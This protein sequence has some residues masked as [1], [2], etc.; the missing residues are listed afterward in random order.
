MSFS[1]KVIG[2]VSYNINCNFTNY[3]SALQ[4]WALCRE[5]QRLGYESVLV[6]YCPT[7]LEDADALNPI[8]RMWDKDDE[9][10][11]L[12]E[13]SMPAIK[14]NFYKFEDFYS[15]C[16]RRTKKKYHDNNFSEIVRDERVER[17][18]CGSDTIFCI[19]EF[20]GFV[21]GYYANFDCMKGNCISYAAS[22]GDMHFSDGEYETLKLRL[23]NF[24]ALGLRENDKV[25]SVKRL[26]NV[27]VQRTID[28]TLLLKQA[29]YDTIAAKRLVAEKYLLLYSRRQNALMYEYAEKVAKRRNLKIVDISLKAIGE[30][31][32]IPYYQAGVEEFLSLVKHAE[33]VV[34][35]SFHGI[36]F[37]VQYRRPF[38][39][40]TRQE[41]NTK[42]NELMELFGLN[43][44]LL[45]MGDEET[46]EIDYEKVHSNIDRAREKSLEFLKKSLELL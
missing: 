20:K 9:L 14:E 21:E 37:S 22:F 29:D 1:M 26:V 43:G 15:N 44:S 27:P 12:V 36:I 24:K 23:Q 4:S 40:F 42:I 7:V 34:T 6:D 17:F 8:K 28:P 19:D 5:I 11:R 45:V 30:S 39:G 10:V 3:G 2:V 18:V 25:E 32:H 38:Y 33:C 46:K 31:D 16:F 13:K 35:N 41:C